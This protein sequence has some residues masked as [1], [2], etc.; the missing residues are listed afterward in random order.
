MN[1]KELLQSEIHHT[2]LVTDGLMKLVDD[3]NLEWKPSHENNWLTTGQLLKH[4]TDACGAP[5]K[6]F[7]TGDWG[8]PEG[9]DIADLSP[10]DM[11]P[12]AEKF[13]TIGSVAEARQLLEK[14]KQLA[15]EMLDKCTEENLANQVTTAPWDSTGVI[16]GQ[17]LLS[18]ISHLTHHKAQLF[19]YLKLQGKKVNTGHLWGG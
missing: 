1:W 11:L 19:Y 7:V 17:R 9:V 13:P 10:E 8:L 14:D 3:N 2:Y 6:G 16:L 18:M 4:L 12:P 5:I 15:L